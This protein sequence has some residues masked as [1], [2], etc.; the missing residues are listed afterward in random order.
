MLKRQ[1]VV[2]K[3][4]PTLAHSINDGVILDSLNETDWYQ[5][6][7]TGRAVDQSSIDEFNRVL[8]INLQP[9]ELQVVDSPSRLD[10]KTDF[11]YGGVYVF[12]FTLK[13]RTTL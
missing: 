13:Q 11:N 7:I 10:N 1:N 9:L 5:F 4:L 6:S 2:E 3:L 8:S 12:E